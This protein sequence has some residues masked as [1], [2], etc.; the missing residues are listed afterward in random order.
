M[1]K[2]Y[3]SGRISGLAR[4]EYMQY[5][6]V[7]EDLLTKEGYKV[8]NPTR[9]VMCR[10]LWLYRILGYTLTLLYDLWRLSQCDLIYKLPGWRQSKGANIESCFA[11]HQHIWPVP[12][13]VA[14]FVDRSIDKIMVKDEKDKSKPSRK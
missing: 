11:Y 7:A 1:K 5:F 12:Q 8:V 13:T 10:Y 4:K 6:H 2:V 9:F 14:L 3:L